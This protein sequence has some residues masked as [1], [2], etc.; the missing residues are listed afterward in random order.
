MILVKQQFFTPTK[1]SLEH[2]AML[3]LTKAL[4]SGPA[5]VPTK[6]ISDLM[7]EPRTLAVKTVK[8]LGPVEMEVYSEKA[9]IYSDH[10]L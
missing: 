7:T 10:F 5:Q 2:L 6:H 1:K 8:Q 4:G 3:W 9:N